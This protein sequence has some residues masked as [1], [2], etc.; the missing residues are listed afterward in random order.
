MAIFNK[1]FNNL[2]LNFNKNFNNF[3]LYIVRLN[4]TESTNE[5]NN[6]VSRFCW[7][8]HTFSSSAT[9]VESVVWI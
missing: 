5:I 2:L 7:S 3:L 4:M 1:K 6:F 8:G 9:T